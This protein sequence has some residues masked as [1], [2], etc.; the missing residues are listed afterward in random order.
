M[1]SIFL[2]MFF[3]IVFSFFLASTRFLNCLI[4][5]ENFNILLLLF[6]LLVSLED[7]HVI[8]VVLMVISTVEIIIGLVIL[9]RVWECSSVV[10]LFFF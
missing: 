3:V 8:F 5:L 10:E 7:S 9:T 1:I 6:C 4:I 2:V